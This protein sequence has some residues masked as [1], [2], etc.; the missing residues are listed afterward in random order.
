MSSSSAL[1]GRR[2]GAAADKPPASP[3]MITSRCL[4]MFTAPAC[5]STAAAAP[6]R[7]ALR[8]H[9]HRRCGRFTRSA[10]SGEAEIRELEG[11]PVL[12]AGGLDRGASSA[13]HDHRD[14][15]HL[16]AGVLQ[17][18][19]RGQRTAAGRR[20][21]LDDEHRPV[22][23]VRTLDPPLQAVRLAGLADDAGVQEPLARGGCVQHRG[24]HRVGAQGEA[25]DDVVAQVAGELPHHP[26]HQRRA[27]VVQGQPAHVDVPV[28]LPA[29]GEGDPPVHHGEL[30]DELQQPVT[31]GEGGGSGRH[32]LDPTEG[33]AS[34]MAHRNRLLAAAGPPA[35]AAAAAV[36]TLATE[37]GSGWFRRLDKP[38]WYPP[39]QTFGIVWTGLYTALGWAAGEVLSRDPARRGAFARASAANLVLNAGWTPLFFRAHR[40]WAAAVESAVLTAST[41][42]LVRRA[43][44]VSR[45]AAAA[46]VPYAVWTAFAAAPTVAI[47]RR[48]PRHGS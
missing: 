33:Q 43:A 10:G 35:A 22:L 39:A 47:A 38:A 13:V 21:V 12:E 2:A 40:P 17:R 30:D 3:P 20:D 18:L 11:R 41:V 14:P 24:R 19:R 7:A 25:A 16:G 31:V 15:D 45:P 29:R 46:L 48:N 26:A 34:G 1:R 42:D 6:V 23:A 9:R 36:G 27:L 4:A 28:R 5:H 37:P 8:T 32:A 44:P